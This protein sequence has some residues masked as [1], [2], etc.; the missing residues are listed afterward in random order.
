LGRNGFREG[1]RVSDM[2]PRPASDAQTIPQITEKGKKSVGIIFGE[3]KGNLMSTDP[4]LSPPVLRK[5]ELKTDG[6]R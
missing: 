2:S 3:G 1:A 4:H 6:R 5:K